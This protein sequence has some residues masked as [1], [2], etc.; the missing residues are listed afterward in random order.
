[1]GLMFLLTSIGKHQ[2]R[3]TENYIPYKT[4]AGVSSK[5]IYSH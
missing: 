4:V 2:V 3:W 5:D 1:M